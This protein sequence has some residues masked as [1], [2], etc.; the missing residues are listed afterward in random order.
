MVG[1]RRIR[2]IVVASNGDGKSRGRARACQ[3]LPCIAVTKAYGAFAHPNDP[4]SP[5][6]PMLRTEDIAVPLAHQLDAFAGDE[7]RDQTASKSVRRAI[8]GSEPTARA[9]SAVRLGYA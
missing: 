6:S 2:D 4:P 3:K 8:G 5:P 1:L 9:Y 7:K